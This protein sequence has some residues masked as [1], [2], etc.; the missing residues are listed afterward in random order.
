MYNTHYSFLDKNVIS[1][2]YFLFI[3]VIALLKCVLAS[4]QENQT[5]A[6]C[7]K[8]RLLWPEYSL[9]SYFRGTHNS[10]ASGINNLNCHLNFMYV[11]SQCIITNMYD[12]FHM[13]FLQNLWTFSSLI[14]L[15]FDVYFKQLVP[16]KYEAPVYT[17]FWTKSRFSFKSVTWF[18]YKYYKV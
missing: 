10:S 16:R 15:I 14:I 12:V 1:Y 4:A 3:Y 7:F 18:I 9:S 8:F 6:V 11:F 5:F 2:V 13:F 17:V